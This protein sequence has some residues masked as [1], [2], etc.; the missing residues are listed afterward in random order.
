[1][2]KPEEIGFVLDTAKMAA[3]LPYLR[4]EVEKMQAAIS[5]SVDQMMALGTLTPE[6]SMNY[7]VETTV[8]RRL[9]NK[10]EQKVTLGASM[11]Q[12]IGSE[13]NRP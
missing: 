9:L 2:V 11:G 3:L 10:F 7:W 5:R 13:M 12:E 6:R 8:L 1:M 4:A